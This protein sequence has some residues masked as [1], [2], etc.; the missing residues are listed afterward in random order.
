MHACQLYYD[1]IKQKN[2]N[3]D[4]NIW[5]R[6]KFGCENRTFISSVESQKGVNAVQGCSFENQK[7]T[8]TT[9]RLCSH[10]GKVRTLNF[11][12]KCAFW[13]KIRKTM[14][15]TLCT[16]NHIAM[17][18]LK[19]A[20]QMTVQ[21][22]FPVTHLAKSHSEITV[23]MPWPLNG[24]IFFFWFF[25]GGGGGGA[26]WPSNHFRLYT[27]RCICTEAQEMRAPCMFDWQGTQTF[28]RWNAKS[29]I[30]SLVCTLRNSNIAI[31]SLVCTLRN[32]KCA[33][34]ITIQNTHFAVVWKQS[35]SMAIALFWFS[36][37]HLWIVIVPFWLSPDNM[38]LILI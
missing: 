24:V 37:K 20:F 16:P 4:S 11:N 34:R 5:K 15:W 17:R 1:E 8:I 35:K 33:F 23:W 21:R 38:F 31:T 14:F 25:F 19:C 13:I 18:N 29:Q 6:F 28:S 30:R 10:D 36:T 26:K 27:A 7:G 2:N 3:V 22:C 32:S 9:Q 12:S